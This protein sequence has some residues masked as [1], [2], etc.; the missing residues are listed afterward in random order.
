[1]LLAHGQTL[2]DQR[3][4][5]S[6]LALQVPVA[7]TMQL[8]VR[9]ASLRTRATIRR[10]Q[11]KQPASVPNRQDPIGEVV[12]Q[13]QMSRKGTFAFLRSLRSRHQLL[14]RHQ[15]RLRHLLR[16]GLEE[17]RPAWGFRWDWLV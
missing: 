17:R 6:P 11:A 1:M 5:Q 8:L 15:D 12:R 14:R 7:R 16:L 4:M 2:E 10:I 3:T 13:Q 9:R